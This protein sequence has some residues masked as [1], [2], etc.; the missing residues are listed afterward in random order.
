MRI[1]IV[2][3]TPRDERLAELCEKNG[4]TLPL[5]GPWDVAVLPL[6][7][8]SVAEETADQLPRGQRIIC[9]LT[10]AAF[11]ALAKKRGWLLEHILED[12]TFVKENAVLTAEGALY[13]AM[14]AVDSAIKD[15]KCLVIGYGRIGQALTGMLRAL[16]ARVTVAARRAESRAAAGP[17]SISIEA[18]GDS[19]PEMET[20]FNTVPAPILQREQLQKANRDTLFLELASAPYGIDVSAA[21]SLG[22]K[23]LPESGLPGRYCPRS[24]A[25]AMLAYIERE[26][27][28]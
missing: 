18:I 13:A 25:A 17:N 6:P 19:L 24:A 14:G 4:H 1:L 10:D 3:Q 16:G 11:D 28:A 23:L 7:R 5:H 22:L 8:S 15:T 9:G 27:E 21:S 20:V 26:G 12:E 2:G